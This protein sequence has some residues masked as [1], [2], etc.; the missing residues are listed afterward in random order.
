M[1]KWDLPQECKIGLIVINVINHI[2]HRLR[3][4]PREYFNRC[5]KNI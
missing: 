4:K 1:T 2:I 3:T 5:R